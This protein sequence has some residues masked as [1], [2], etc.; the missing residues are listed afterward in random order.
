MPTTLTVLPPEKNVT[1][2]RLDPAWNR[3][4]ELL[5]A[6][7][8]S[9]R[10]LAAEIERLRE[11]YLRQGQGRRTDIEPSSHGETKVEDGFKAQVSAQLGIGP[12]TAYR[13]L[14]MAKALAI[15][16]MVEHAPDGETIDLPDEGTYEVTDKVRCKARDLRAR[17]ESGD[18]A[19]NRALPAVSGM[20]T[21][22]GGGTGGKAATNHPANI[23]AGL[24]KL[25]TSLGAKH[26]RQGKGDWDRNASLWAHVLEQLPEASLPA[27][28]SELQSTA[29]DLDPA[30]VQQLQVQFGDT[31]IEHGGRLK[32]EGER[33][34]AFFSG[35]LDGSVP[36]THRMSLGQP[37]PAVIAA[38][39]AGT[40][41]PKTKL[42][43]QP[44]D[45]RHI[46]GQHGRPDV[47]PG[48]LG[49]QRGDQRPLEPHELA[50]LPHIWRQPDSVDVARDGGLILRKKLA[51][52]FEL[53]VVPK[54]PGA[55]AWKPSSMRVKR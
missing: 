16:D 30:T 12:A 18:V 32:W 44:D 19:M 35:S 43:V 48:R 14:A 53:I 28:N 38:A 26:W 47:V 42:I 13:H 31:L 25:I 51:G 4:R 46:I 10:D 50:W 7:R 41:T 20:F 54:E 8:Q 49:E 22:R 52:E 15:C 5:A 39:P 2:V 27:F 1:P 24:Q 40:F 45:L 29:Q 21:V 17:I 34:D 23:Y 6:G 3:A 36:Q 33:I 11:L 37:E 9:A 55:H